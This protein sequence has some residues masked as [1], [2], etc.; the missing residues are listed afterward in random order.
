MI[1]K[2]IYR[3][4][5]QKKWIAAQD[6]RQVVLIPFPVFNIIK[7]VLNLLILLFIGMR[8]HFQ[9]KWN[10]NVI[11]LREKFNVEVT[12]SN[13]ASGGSMH[14]LLVNELHVWQLAPSYSW[15]S[16]VLWIKIESFICWGPW[17]GVLSCIV[18]QIYLKADL[19]FIQWNSAVRILLDV[20]KLN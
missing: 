9:M 19:P 7:L 20:H 14:I 8:L 13:F 18:P 5:G 10:G 6:K 16:H 17:V 3:F 1:I 12:M 2:N 15:F 4:S 11:I